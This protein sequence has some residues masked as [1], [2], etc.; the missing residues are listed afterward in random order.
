VYL[1]A[2]QIPARASDNAVAFIDQSAQRAQSAF[3]QVNRPQPNL[4]SAWLSEDDSAVPGKQW[5]G[6]E[7]GRAQR[8][9]QLKRDV[10]LYIA[11]CANCKRIPAAYNI[12]AKGP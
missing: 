1:S 12:A 4:A 10:V 2:P 5:P 7:Y 9:T 8:F 6:K 11:I 3:M